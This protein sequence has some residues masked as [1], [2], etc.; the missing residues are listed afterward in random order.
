MKSRNRFGLGMI[1]FLVMFFVLG[2]S[3]SA[4]CEKTVVYSGLCGPDGSL[5]VYDMNGT[6]LKASAA[7]NFSGCYRGVYS[8][9]IGSGGA[10]CVIT[11][12][13]YLDFRINDVSV[14]NPQWD[15]IDY[16]VNL[17]IGS[18]QPPSPPPDD[19]GDGGGI[20]Y[21][22]GGGGGG[23]RGRRGQATTIFAE[24]IERNIT[25]LCSNGI[26]DFGE[27][28]IDCGGYCPN[29]CLTCFDGI[30]NQGE[31]GVDCGGPCDIAC[32]TCFDGIMNQG[33]E[34]V[35]CGGPC[36]AICP[37]CFDGIM[38]QDEEG[39]DCGGPC[40]PCVKPIVEIP[41]VEKP[42]VLWLWILILIIIGA[43]I[44]VLVYELR[45][46]KEIMGMFSKKPKT[47]APPKAGAPRKPISFTVAK[48]VAKAP[49]TTP[50]TK[51]EV[52]KLISDA[53]VNL[54]KNNMSKV[55]QLIDEISNKYKQLK[56]AD[57]PEIY[58]RYIDLYKLVKKRI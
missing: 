8:I 11:P 36:A 1:V 53:Y 58:K 15:G 51:Q 29:V 24:D 14:A 3:V 57:K 12:L 38:N 52:N 39:I 56:P 19:G 28:G 27:D 22:G 40:E 17:N 42:S 23:G 32:P 13:Q 30:M 43:L 26:R 49:I 20:I 41:K 33:E 46:H 7:G 16:T 31:E 18:W 25:A 55:H 37:T 47:L 4:V 54:D 35:D 48:P 44:G 34:G 9:E 50:V 2:M 5:D 6:L 21:R 10:S 45:Q